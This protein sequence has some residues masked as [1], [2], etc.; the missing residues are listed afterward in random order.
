MV[1]N[2]SKCSFKGELNNSHFRLCLKCNRKRLEESNPK[3]TQSIVKRKIIARK[4]IR[5][6]SDKQKE[7]DKKLRQVY[8]KIG[9]DRE[10]KCEG[11]HKQEGQV[12]LSHS[13]TIPRSRRKDLIA[14]K[15]NIGYHCLSMGE[16]IGCHDKF[17]SGNL[18]IMNKLFDFESRME[19][20]K[21]NDEEYYNLLV[22]KW[23]KY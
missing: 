2:C 12:I 4:P 22:T 14:D 17:A 15:N 18:E 13:H 10:R 3:D 9:L 16:H 20:I 7:S 5:I 21:S 19:Y 11:C 1:G 23:G 8:E 6:K